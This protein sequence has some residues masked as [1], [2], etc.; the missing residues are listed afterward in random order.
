MGRGRRRVRISVGRW[1]PTRLRRRRKPDSP[2]PPSTPIIHSVPNAKDP[3][4]RSTMDGPVESNQRDERTTS[5]SATHCYRGT[6]AAPHCPLP[7]KALQNTT[8]HTQQNT[9]HNNKHTRTPKAPRNNNKTQRQHSLTQPTNQPRTHSLPPTPQN[10]E[11]SA[12]QKSKEVNERTNKQTNERLTDWLA[13]RCPRSLT[14]RLVCFGCWMSIDV[15]QTNERRTNE[16]RT[17]ARTNERTNARCVADS[18]F[19]SLRAS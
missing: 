5:Q 16:R 9:T 3:S 4:L 19:E 18:A 11:D 1:S 10:S 2:S 6:S 8:L 17:N 7:S 13:V 12:S 15:E 14:Q